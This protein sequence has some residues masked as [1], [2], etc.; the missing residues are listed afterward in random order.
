MILRMTIEVELDEN[1]WRTLKNVEKLDEKV[2][3]FIEGE[4]FLDLG[5]ITKVENIDYLEHEVKE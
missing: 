3:Q 1:S 5:T 4:N 2:K